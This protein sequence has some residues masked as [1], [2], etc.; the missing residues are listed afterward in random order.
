[1]KKYTLPYELEIEAE[2]LDDAEE[3]AEAKAEELKK[4]VRLKTIKGEN[5][6]CEKFYE[7]E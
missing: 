3:L 1:M 2:D 7:A 6:S 5:E 4:K